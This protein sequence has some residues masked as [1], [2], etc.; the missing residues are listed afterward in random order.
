MKNETKTY[1]S[2]IQ[3]GDYLHTGLNSD[4]Y[5]ECVEAVFGYLSEGMDDDEEYGAYADFD[6]AKREQIALM[7]VEIEEH[8]EPLPDEDDEY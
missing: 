4:T 5:E 1:Y 3:D 7:H 8:A 2:A 6:F